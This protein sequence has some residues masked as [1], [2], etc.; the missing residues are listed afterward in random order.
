M[1][2][3]QVF[4]HRTFVALYMCFAICVVNT[5][6][7]DEAARIVNARVGIQGTVKI[8]CWTPVSFEIAEGNGLQFQPLVRTSD[9]DGNP[10]IQQ[11]P[12]VQVPQASDAPVTVQGLFRPGRTGT[13]IQL[14]LQNVDQELPLQWVTVLNE[15]APIKQLRQTTQVWLTIG[16]QPPFPAASERWN[17]LLENGVHLIEFEE[18]NNSDS[19][20]PISAEGLDMVD[21]IAMSAKL[22]LSVSDSMAIQNWV[23]RGGR[24]VLTI[25]DSF[26]TFKDGPLADWVPLQPV[27]AGE[28]RNLSGLNAAVPGSS[29]LRILGSMKAA[30]L[31]EV[32]GRV[33]ASGITGPLLMRAAYGSG[34]VTVL[35]IDLDHN[36]LANWDYTSLTDFAGI[37]ANLSPPWE[38]P[39]LVKHSKDVASN[40]SPTGV[41]DL[42][43]QLVNILDNFSDVQRSSHWRILG[44]IS[45]FILLI[46]PLDYF[47]L[48][49]ILKKPKLTWIT[50]PVWIGLAS[51]FATSN[52]TAVNQQPLQLRQV[53]VVDF[54]ATVSKVR[55][56]SWMNF[57]SPETSR[58]EI[59]AQLSPTLSS[60]NFTPV[61]LRTSFVE[62]PETSFRG[63]YRDGDFDQGKPSYTISANR[64][65]ILNLPSTA[66]SSGSASCE[67]E[68]G[69]GEVGN[70]ELIVE[71]TNRISGQLS[72]SLPFEIHDW[73][74]SFGSFVY[75]PRGEDLRVLSKDEAVDL[76]SLGSNLLK[77]VMIGLKQSAIYRE[78]GKRTD[79]SVTRDTYNIYDDDPFLLLRMISFHQAAGG[80]D[81]THLDNQSNAELDL[82]Q[83]IQQHRA[84]LF[85][86][87]EEPSV[88]FK[89]DGKEPA[90]KLNETFIRLIY[91]VEKKL[92]NND[93]A[94]D[95]D[96]LKVVP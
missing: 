52:A 83:L 60:I 89:I 82:T 22:T 21:L 38:N 75:Y 36:P 1:P 2:S 81:Y 8:G 7:A 6:S 73:F 26:Q 93:A 17:S 12:I 50:L 86:R 84:V 18:I 59:S 32:Q 78:R 33:L 37:L 39:S 25:G 87:I 95:A 94:P 42:Q 70:S 16:D 76:E 88:S 55:G 40:L 85:G 68:A 28:V 80:L 67:W 46:G 61:F 54:D 24:L 69:C 48:H 53:N 10:V 65:K 23:Q 35:A 5:A 15:T 13:S 11:L 62:R 72:H 27:G 19:V 51:L 30:E 92:R 74:L 44:W 47:L 29:P 79:A 64:D 31:D 9:P 77:G 91:P 49:H 34:Q 90:S 58:N 14:A 43:T 63:M 56:K 71:G 96:F 66:W 4:S 57:Y 41:S 20:L 45:L 3:N